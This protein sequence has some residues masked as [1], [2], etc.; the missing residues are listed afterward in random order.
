MRHNFAVTG[1]VYSLRPIENGDAQFVVELRNC[2]ELG[3]Y[4]H[5]GAQSSSEQLKWLETYYARANDYYFVVE[6][7]ASQAAEGLIALYD[8]DETQRS[9]EWGR[10]LLKPGSLAATE[11]A[12]LI[13]QFAFDVLSLNQV[14]CR[15]VE[16]NRAVVS[17]H[18]SCTE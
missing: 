5:R 3:K 10:W 8:V 4:I 13:Y 2:A 17:F 15:T 16:E 14:Y 18:V 11:S 6:K 12:F 7:K 9:A 1:E